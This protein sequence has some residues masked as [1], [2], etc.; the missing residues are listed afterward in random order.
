MAVV[1]SYTGKTIT[2]KAL[3]APTLS[4]DYSNLTQNN[5]NNASNNQINS[6]KSVEADLSEFLDDF[7]EKNTNNVT[8]MEFTTGSV[9]GNLSIEEKITLYEK[10]WDGV[11]EAGETIAVGATS[12]I[13]G[14][15]DIAEGLVDS[16][17]WT[18]GKVVEGSLGIEEAELPK[19]KAWYEKL[20]D[21]VKE[22]GATIAVGAT[23]VISG[24]ADIGEGLVDGLAWTGGKVVE[25]ASWLVGETAGIF[26]EDAKEDVMS[27]RENFKDNEHD[28]I[29]TDWVGE[30][31]KALYENTSIGRAINEASAMKYDSNLAQGISNVS[32][33]AGKVVIATAATVVTGGAAAPIAAG[34]LFGV[35]DKAEKVYQSGE[36]GAKEEL[37]I[38]VSGLGEAANWYALGK[39][40]QG[41]TQ[42]AGVVKTNGLKATTSTVVNG[43]KTT[44]NTIKTNGVVN[45]A[46]DVFHATKGILSNTSCKSLITADNLSDSIGIIGDNASRWLTGEEEFNLNTAAKAGGELLLAW[47]LNSFFDS[48]T[49]YLEGGSPTPSSTAPTGDIPESTLNTGAT[50]DD[51]AEIDTPTLEPQLERPRIQPQNL[52]TKDEVKKY[53]T[54]MVDGKAPQELL[55]PNG[56]LDTIIESVQTYF[57]SLE[58]TGN[59]GGVYYDLL[60]ITGMEI[61]PSILS[62]ITSSTINNNKYLREIIRKNAMDEATSTF[63]K[64]LKI[65]DPET[66]NKIVDAILGSDFVEKGIGVNHNWSEFA[67]II[68]PHVQQAVAD[69]S[70]LQEAVL[71][72]KVDTS[73]LNSV[74]TTIETTTVGDQNFKIYYSSNI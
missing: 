3:Q 2:S 15:A 73:A 70:L 40:G 24:I 38:F 48:A 52:S 31:N 49:R 67:D 51:V 16:L 65:E 57:K 47:G 41:A 45:T 61:P 63:G 29:A 32:E 18:G 10:L 56:N 43:V 68:S 44:I 37:G 6:S 25:G 64:I 7:E 71:W 20:W 13:S 66:I 5:H 21:G 42:L 19:E 39:L 69:G 36:T 58:Q 55:G 59:I 12:V 54:L 60:E 28:F 17:A 8:N 72:S 35:G 46:K 33:M 62:D 26:S 14:I 34:F 27:W 30:A 23:S 11:K 4:I 9:E 1:G 53:I 74:Y 50:L 22:T